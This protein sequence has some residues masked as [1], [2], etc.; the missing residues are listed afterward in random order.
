MTEIVPANPLDVV[1]IDRSMRGDLMEDG[2]FCGGVQSGNPVVWIRG[3]RG[4]RMESGIMMMV[5]MLNKKNVGYDDSG[6]V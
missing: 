4:I 1:K 5:M 6:E 2:V 3:T